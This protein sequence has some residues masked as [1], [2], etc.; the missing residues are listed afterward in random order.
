MHAK[1]PFL[2]PCIGR[3]F[4]NRK[5][6]FKS[7]LC[8]YEIHE[9]DG[10]LVLEV[11]GNGFLYKMVR[12]MTGALLGVGQ[13]KFSIADVERKLEVGNSVPPGTGGLWRGYQVAAAK[14]LFLHHVQYPPGIDDPDRLIY[15]DMLHDEHGRPLGW[16][17]E[18][19]HQQEE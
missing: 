15:P 11:E 8:S 16:L 7:Y 10:G 17:P 12:H 3:G 18:P 9:V 1:V 2:H 4:V 14:G 13:G 6:K 19:S 5:P